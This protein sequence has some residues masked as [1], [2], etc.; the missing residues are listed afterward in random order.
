[1]MV[2]SSLLAKK[3]STPDNSQPKKLG[4]FD[5]WQS[6]IAQEKD[7]KVC[8]MVSFPIHQEGH[9]KKRGKP[10]VMITH[11][12][13]DKSFDV[14]SLHAG[15]KLS[16]DKKPLVLID[17][18]KEQKD[19]EMFVDNESAWA[20]SDDIDQEITNL[21]IK[22]GTG[23]KVKGESFKGTKTI[24]TYSLKGSYAAYQAINQACQVHRP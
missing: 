11:R 5:H 9:Y 8:Y 3:Q 24:D 4:E 22:T 14:I 18:S 16:K 1:M 13:E 20:T 19:Y 10:Y 2:C 15:Y 6:F 12:P 7:K 17:V 23:L 21:I